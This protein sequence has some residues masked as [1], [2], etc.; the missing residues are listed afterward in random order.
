VQEAED[1]EPVE[2]YHI[3][4]GGG[5]GEHAALGRELFRD[6][7]ATDAPQTIERVLNAYVANRSSPQESFL[8]FT[9]RYNDAALK[10]LCESGESA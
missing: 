4:I 9:E 3:H 7:K 5:F 1:A 6:V 8:A 10:A 2:G